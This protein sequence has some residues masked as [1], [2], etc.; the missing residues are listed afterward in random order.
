[1]DS[2][3]LTKLIFIPIRSKRQNDRKYTF[4]QTSGT[5]R[6]V[7]DTVLFYDGYNEDNIII[8]M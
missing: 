4:A 2:V 3:V 5:D 6:N 1:M 7:E 8:I